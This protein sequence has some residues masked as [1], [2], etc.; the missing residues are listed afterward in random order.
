ME[1]RERVGDLEKEL[2][3]I[4]REQVREFVGGDQWKSGERWLDLL[5]RAVG[6][7]VKLGEGSRLELKRSR[8]VSL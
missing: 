7:A 1:W 4:V 6:E 3:R 8:E 2:R 5:V